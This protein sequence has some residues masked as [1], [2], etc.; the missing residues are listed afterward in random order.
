[1]QYMLLAY[2]YTVHVASILIT[3]IKSIEILIIAKSYCLQ[4]LNYSS[5]TT[6]IASVQLHGIQSNYII[7][8]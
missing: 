1:M 4:L 8:Q 5:I 7:Q 3:E 6:F 2:R